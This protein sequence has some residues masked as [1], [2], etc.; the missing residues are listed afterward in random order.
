MIFASQFRENVG[1]S[2]GVD[3]RFGEKQRP[4]PRLVIQFPQ[5]AFQF[6][7]T[8]MLQDH[9]LHQGTRVLRLL[10]HR[11]EEQRQR[12]DTA[13][14]RRVNRIGIQPQ[15]KPETRDFSGQFLRKNR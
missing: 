13:T 2:I 15:Q 9:A 5:E 8:M 6:R 4:F 14:V 11:R 1:I 10:W 12:G 7:W 3:R